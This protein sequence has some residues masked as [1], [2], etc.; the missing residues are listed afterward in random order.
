VVIRAHPTQEKLIK[1]MIWVL[2]AQASEEWGVRM[3]FLLVP[4][5]PGTYTQLAKIAHCE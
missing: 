3:D 2:R 5:E 1:G 4:T